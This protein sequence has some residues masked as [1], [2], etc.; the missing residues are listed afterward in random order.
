MPNNESQAA[1]RRA[2]IENVLHM[3]P[4][5]RE[6]ALVDDGCGG[7]VALVVPDDSYMDEVLGRGAAEST[8]LS[9]WR[10]TFD[11]SQLSRE[12]ATVPVGFNTLGWNSSYT[13][14][15]FPLDDMYEWVENTVGEILQ[16]SPK[17]VCEIGC[18]TGMLT[19][20]IALHCDKYLAVD[21]SPVVLD[22]LRGQLQSVPAVAAR[23]EVMQSRADNLDGI[24]QNSFDAVVINSVIQYFPSVAY[25]TKVLEGAL[26]IVRPGG[27]IYV[28]D[29]RSLPLL[30][31]F[32]TSVELFQAADEISA[33]D[34]RDRI[35]RRIERDQEL[36]LSPA[37][38]LSLRNS[39]P[40]VSRVDIHPLRGRADNEM[41]RFRYQAILHVDHPK[42]AQ[43]DEE[44]LDWTEGRCTLDDIRSMLLQHQNQ[45]VRIK[46]I[47]NARIEKDLKALAILAET[48]MEPTAGA[49]R[50]ELEQTISQGI[51]PQSLIDLESERLGFKVFLSMGAGRHDGSYDACFIPASE[52]QSANLLAINWP[53]PDASEFVRFANAPGQ[54]KMRNEVTAQLIAFCSQN[55]PPESMPRE[56]ILVDTLARIP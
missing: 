18:G 30:P 21:F 27:H 49:L 38:F 34:L 56:I 36:V 29:V 20:R 2:A 4:A 1:T 53:Q 42:Q 17:S 48:D 26:R 55:L 9:K 54:V 28:G 5:V 31:V 11:L 16:L 3:H 44:F 14:G 12:A 41:T 52:Q 45:R 8:V 10:K 24:E 51:H 15:T 23:V 22:R 35:H 50:R 47:A 43:S 37:Y 39:F 32:A 25:L 46:C 6:A 33:G 13:R 19:I 40:K 7:F